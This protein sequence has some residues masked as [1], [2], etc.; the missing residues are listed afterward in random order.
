MANKTDTARKTLKRDA[1]IKRLAD[2][3][4][5]EDILL[6]MLDETKLDLILLAL[7]I[8]V[9]VLNDEALPTT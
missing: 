7:G 2:I 8:G 6:G 4:G 3:R 5:N 9:T 1:I